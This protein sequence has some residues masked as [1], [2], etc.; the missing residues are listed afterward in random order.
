MED[1]VAKSPDTRFLGERLDK[2]VLLFF[3]G[4]FLF[5]GDSGRMHSN[6]SVTF[7]FFVG[8]F[9]PKPTLIE[10]DA[11][12]CS[13]GCETIPVTVALKASSSCWELSTNC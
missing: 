7:I 5:A 6:S 12:S 4:D 13:I 8:I 1:G 3:P 2:L 9:G 10:V 11:F